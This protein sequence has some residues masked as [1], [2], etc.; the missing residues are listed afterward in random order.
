MS[1]TTKILDSVWP[2]IESPTVSEQTVDTQKE[3]SL[4]HRIRN[5]ADPADGARSAIFLEAAQ[6]IL[7][8]EDGRKSS[9]ES[10]AT[11]FIAAL[12]AL[13]PLMTWALGNTDEAQFVGWVLIAWAAA[14]ILSVAY[15]VA[16][17]YWAL[18]AI[19]V[20]NYNVV[21]VE[22]IVEISEHNQNISTELIKRALLS[23][24]ANRA[25][26]NK[27]I[28]FIKVSQA[29]FV[30]GFFVLGA[31]LIFDPISRFHVVQ[32]ITE[33]FDNQ[34]SHPKPAEN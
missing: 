2:Y 19:N 9:A 12:A 31:L 5:L 1:L 17:T 23:A 34:E 8:Y 27:K 21:G 25:T 18:R 11:A 15:F 13:I 4:R 28:A 6:K 3:T 14:F 20:A 16:A 32:T 24:L 7:D 33:K 30:R 10:R 29:H 26:I 22:E